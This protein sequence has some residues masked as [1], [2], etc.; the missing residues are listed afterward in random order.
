MQTITNDKTRSAAR[1][2]TDADGWF[3]CFF[4]R[5][6]RGGEFVCAHAKPSRSYKTEKGAS[7]AARNW[8]DNN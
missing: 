4:G 2:F 5:V 1:I 6:E 3:L 7:K 8:T